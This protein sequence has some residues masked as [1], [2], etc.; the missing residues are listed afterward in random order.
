MFT[1]VQCIMFHT[2]TPQYCYFFR[3]M[4][5]TSRS[6]SFSSK[7]TSSRRWSGKFVKGKSC[8]HLYR[9]S[10]KKRNGG[11]SVTM[12]AKNV[13]FF[14]Y[15][16]RESIFR[17]REWHQDHGEA[18]WSV[19]TK[20]TRINGLPHNTIMEGFSR[21]NS[22]LIGRKNQAKSENNC[23]SRSGHRFKTTQPNLMILVSFSS[24]EY[25]LSND[26]TNSNT[27]SSQGIYWK[28]LPFRFFGTPGI[29]WY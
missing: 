12:Q 14:F 18:H 28:I 26:V 1:P 17:R 6:S 13:I 25:A 22:L 19:A 29:C 8:L 16:I 3:E 5:Y 9:M 7:E 20:D 4:Q 24:V 21:H 15:I 2:M 11:F 23:I 27:F 10:Q